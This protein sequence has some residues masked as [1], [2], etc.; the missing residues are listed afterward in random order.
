MIPFSQIP[1][2]M[3]LPSKDFS[4]SQKSVWPRG[5][6]CHTLARE[7]YS[8]EFPFFDMGR[9]QSRPVEPERRPDT[10]QTGQQRPQCPWACGSCHSQCFGRGSGGIQD[11]F[12]SRLTVR[13]S[14]NFAN[15]STMCPCSNCLT[16]LRTSVSPHE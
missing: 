10:Y 15:V 1:M 14:S 7:Q 4:G 13:S 2:F 3:W 6:T 9:S 5:T 11:C 16:S 12:S 8:W